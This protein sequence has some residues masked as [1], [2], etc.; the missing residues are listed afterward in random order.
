MAP[1]KAIGAIDVR[2]MSARSSGMRTYRLWLCLALPIAAL[3]SGCGSGTPIIRTVNLGEKAYVGQLSYTAFDTQWLVSLGDGANAR[4]PQNRF[5]LVHVNVVNGGRG[6]ASV[7]TFTLLDDAGQTFSELTSG[8]GVPNWMGI[9]RKVK[10]AESE[11]GNIAFDVA[12]AHYRLRV[13]DE[14][15]DRYAYIDIPLTFEGPIPTIPP[16]APG[17]NVPLPSPK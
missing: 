8:E 4:L 2:L 12:P 5:F 1:S 13:N 17:N 11:T 10:P 14:T 3:L 16:L 9:V 6:D 7:P 15:E